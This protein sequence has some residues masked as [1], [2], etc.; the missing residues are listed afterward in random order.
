MNSIVIRHGLLGIAIGFVLSISF[1]VFWGA[2]QLL[3]FLL[4][5][6]AAGGGG[7]VLGGHLAGRIFG[8]ERSALGIIGAAFGAVVV[9]V[10][11]FV[12]FGSY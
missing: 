11:I 3:G 2:F 6:I 9:R 8:A 10:A 1:Y 12:A 7:G 5:S 4:W